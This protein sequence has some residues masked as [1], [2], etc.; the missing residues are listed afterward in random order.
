MHH[1]P[2]GCFC[3]LMSR[4]GLTGLSESLTS[5]APAERMAACRVY[6]PLADCSDRPTLPTSRWPRS[7][8]PRAPT[9]CLSG[10]SRNPTSGCC[11]AHRRAQ[12]ALRERSDER[13]SDQAL[14]ILPFNG[15]ADQWAEYIRQLA[16]PIIATRRWVIN[17]SMRDERYGAS[18]SVQSLKRIATQPGFWCIRGLTPRVRAR[19]VGAC[20]NSRRSAATALT[21]LPAKVRS[22]PDSAA[23]QFFYL[24]GVGFTCPDRVRT[25]CRRCRHRACRD[26]RA[27]LQRLVRPPP[28]ALHRNCDNIRTARSQRSRRETATYCPRSSSPAAPRSNRPQRQ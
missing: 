15:G 24:A 27:N 21:N 20:R 7:L 10:L 4:S 23:R 16:S 22:R 17:E 1:S 25:R 11:D 13:A 26:S 12:R 6:C 28:R 5:A 9:T 2:V 3:D 19:R 14:A 18:R 8:P